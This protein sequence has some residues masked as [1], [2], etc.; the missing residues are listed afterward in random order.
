MNNRMNC[1]NIK[2]EKTSED[3]AYIEV[4][5][6]LVFFFAVKDAELPAKHGIEHNH[7]VFPILIK[8]NL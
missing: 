8:V 6:H 4:N 5:L 7:F 2:N 3:C 1:A